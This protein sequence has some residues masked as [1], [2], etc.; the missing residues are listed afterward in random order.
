[1]IWDIK[2]GKFVKEG[3]MFDPVKRV[4]VQLIPCKNSPQATGGSVEAGGART[5]AT[6]TGRQERN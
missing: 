1:M 4:L 2:L 5:A 3:R 6:R